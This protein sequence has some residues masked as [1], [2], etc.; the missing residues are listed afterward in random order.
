MLGSDAREPLARHL[1]NAADEVGLESWANQLK[2]PLAMLIL[3]GKRGVST[4]EELFAL[5][6]E[7]LEGLFVGT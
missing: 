2:G 5:S 6:E 7:K 1:L 3:V 4:L